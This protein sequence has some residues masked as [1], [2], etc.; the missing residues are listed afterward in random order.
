MSE[1]V[2]IKQKFTEMSYKIG[3]YCEKMLALEQKLFESEN[4]LKET[5]I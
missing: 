3:Q 1:R 4:E 5:K 2:D